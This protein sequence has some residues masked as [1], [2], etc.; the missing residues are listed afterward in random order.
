[1]DND[2]FDFAVRRGFALTHLSKFICPEVHRAL[3]VPSIG[4]IVAYLNV[5]PM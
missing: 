2:R 3:A 5:Q 4:L 1:V